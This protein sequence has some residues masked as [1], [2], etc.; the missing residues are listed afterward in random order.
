MQSLLEVL[1]VLYNHDKLFSAIFGCNFN[2]IV[3]AFA[4]VEMNAHPMD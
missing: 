2:D 4:A 3:A 1:F